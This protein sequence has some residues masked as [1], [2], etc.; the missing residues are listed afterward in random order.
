MLF[1]FLHDGKRLLTRHVS[2]LLF[3]LKQLELLIRS[4]R[5]YRFFGSSLLIIYDGMDETSSIDV[6]IIDFAHCVTA[7]EMQEKMTTM[8]WPPECPEEPDHGYL[9]GLRTLID[10]FEQMLVDHPPA[11][12]QP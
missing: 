1:D 12:S 6:R 3:K 11:P 2:Q 4:L 9:L 5:G 8:S 10:T 7:R